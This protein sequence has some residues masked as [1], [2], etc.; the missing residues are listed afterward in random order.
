MTL[1]SLVTTLQFHHHRANLIQVCDFHISY[2][3]L[4]ILRDNLSVVHGELMNQF[5]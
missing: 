2:L 3:V 1:G 5:N 4:V